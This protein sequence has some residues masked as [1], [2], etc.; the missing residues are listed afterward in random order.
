[1]IGKSRAVMSASRA[2]GDVAA[3]LHRCREAVRAR[4]ESPVAEHNLASLLGDMGD[5]AGALRASERALAKGGR[6]PET[7][8]VRARALQALGALD[9]AEQGYVAAIAARA[10]YAT[11]HRDLAQLRW[12]RTANLN[13]AMAALAVAPATLELAL[14]RST[15]LQAGGDVEAA[16][17][18]LDDALRR[19]PG[20]IALLLAAAALAARR[21]RPEEQ[22][23]HA[24]AALRAAPGNVAAARAAVEALL[25]AGRIEESVA[26]AER[27]VAAAPDDQGAIALL[28]TAWR[29]AGDG[30]HAAL[31]DDPAL[32][33]TACI[34]VP[35]GWPDLPAFLTDLAGALETL[36]AWRTHPLE[37]SLRHGSQTQVDLT[38]CDM[39]VIR[40]LFAALDAPI[41]AH[42]DRLGPGNDPV[43]RRATG[44]YRFAGAWSVRLR[45]GGYHEDHVHPAGW[46][47]SAF[48]V[49]LPDAGR[50]AP[51]G[52][53]S[54]GRPGVPTRPPLAP[55]RQIAP[56]P[57]ML[58][59]FPSY[60]WHGTE[61]FGG[62]RPRLTV[63]F[64]LVPG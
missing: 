10:D 60:L 13:H 42:I 59:L 36:H 17:T 62:E 44:D 26:L 51:E 38:R 29:L 2:A 56:A 54:L 5:P 64:D 21:K 7:Q 49:A 6:A 53:L 31:C 52:W 40:A 3:A 41:R 1:M 28:A 50:P 30:R 58:A 32:V 23:R 48:Y 24:T 22:L 9:T 20:E 27:I 61:P 8:L 15:V 63:A 47:S 19:A 4:P 43:R 18:V 57:G 46:I 39:P 16:A 55:S 33:S 12:M 11:A 25:H 37:Q 14:V 35:A 34:A 45:P